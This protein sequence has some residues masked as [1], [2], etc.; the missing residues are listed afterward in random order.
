MSNTLEN[1]TLTQQTKAD[2]K[3][4]LYMLHQK[5]GTQI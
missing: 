5:A 3:T 4:V 1:C 2:M